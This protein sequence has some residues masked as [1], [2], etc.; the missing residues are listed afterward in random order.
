V[1]LP[2]D[3]IIHLAKGHLVPL[4]LEGPPLFEA[5][6]VSRIKRE[7]DKMKKMEPIFLHRKRWNNE[8]ADAARGAWFEVTS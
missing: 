3:I 2:A 8:C 1:L 5:L 6:A 4:A 7:R